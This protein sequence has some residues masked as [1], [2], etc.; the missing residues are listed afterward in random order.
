MSNPKKRLG[1]RGADEVK[2]HPFFKGV[3]FDKVLRKEYKPPFVPKLND[4]LDLRYFDETF[5]ELRVDSEKNDDKDE[6]DDEK[7]DFKFEGFSYQQKDENLKNE[8][9]DEN[10]ENLVVNENNNEVEEL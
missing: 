9:N 3:D 5:T 1:S 4:D 2:Q 8:E 7:D 10:D 6:G